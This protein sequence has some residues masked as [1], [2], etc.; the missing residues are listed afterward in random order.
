MY[1]MAQKLLTQIFE[2]ANIGRLNCH[3]V[4]GPGEGVNHLPHKYNLKV[5][6]LE[7]FCLFSHVCYCP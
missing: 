4:L 3:D 2:S 6:L 5:M 1:S 7:L